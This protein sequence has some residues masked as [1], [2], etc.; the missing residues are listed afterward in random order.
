MSFGFPARGRFN[1]PKY[2]SATDIAG[3]IAD[4]VQTT[5]DL[6][7]VP[8]SAREDKQIRLVEDDGAIFYFDAQAVSGD[9]APVSG[10]GFWIR[11]NDVVTST[12]PE[13]TSAP[14]GDTKGI[15][16]VDSDK[17][18]QIIGGVLE[19]KLDPDNTISF[20][21]TGGLRVTPG[22]VIMHVT[23]HEA[24]GDD[25]LNVAGL[26][27]LL[28]DAQTPL[29]HA[30]THQDGGSDEIATA[31]STANAIPK[32]DS[33]G[34]LES[35]WGGD[36]DTLATLDSS[37]YLPDDETELVYRNI[38]QTGL[39]TGGVVSIN[40]GD[41]TLFDVTAGSGLIVNT[42]TDPDNPTITRVTWNA[43]TGVST[44]GLG[45]SFITYVLINSS[46]ALVQ[47]TTNPTPSQLRS[48][49]LLA[50]LF[51]PNGVNITAA[52]RAI[53]A[54]S[55][56]LAGVDFAKAFGP[57]NIS[58]N[59]FSPNGANLQVDKSSGEI[60]S[61]G[62]NVWTTPSDPHTTVLGSQ[63]PV[64]FL[65][66]VYRD[67]IGGFTFE[68]PTS[69]LDPTRY[70]DGSGTPAVVGA[71]QWTLQRLFL[72]PLGQIFVALGQNLFNTKE[73]AIS[74][75][76][77]P[78]DLPV[79]A[80]EGVMRGWIALRGGATALNSTSDAEFVAAGRLGITDISA[81]TSSGE[82]NEGV[83][84]G[85]DGVGV[86]DSKSG[87]TL[88]F[89]NVAPASP[90]VTVN[91]N[92]A[93]IDID[94]ESAT[95]TQRGAA[96][97]ATQAETDTG[98]DDLRIVTPLK[99][100][101]TLSTRVVGPGSATG[102]AITRYDGTTGKLVKNSGLRITDTPTIEKNANDGTGIVIGQTPAGANTGSTVQVLSVTTTQRDQLVAANGMVIYN[103]TLG[104]L[105]M[106]RNG[107]WTSAGKK[108]IVCSFGSANGTGLAS[109]DAAFTVKAR[110]YFAGTN[111][112]GALS[113]ITII[114][115]AD[116][117][118]GR[119][120]IFDLTN[121]L[122]IGTSVTIPSGSAPTIRTIT[123]ANVPTGQ[124]IWEVQM[125]RDTGTG[126]NAIRCSSLSLVFS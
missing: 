30:S 75:I 87:I 21:T 77:V 48:L 52:S 45:S 92:G 99:L 53:P 102:N 78:I 50:I 111:A 8:P 105:Q 19:T 20:G 73:D 76:G 6:A 123:P 37:G 11:S 3:R 122:I 110:L 88:Q 71:N 93:D 65:T 38:L 124:A 70:D 72:T 84:I 41:P 118:T 44:T 125:I 120:R 74:E 29:S 90:A 39:R 85:V 17:G 33:S 13:A 81:G 80:N 31:T 95:E 51:H 83:N 63:V 54:L 112:W 107:V 15:L 101:T 24:G 115:S 94:V 108:D 12:V 126:G 43:F 69:L 27:G 47:Q 9:V 117:A 119:V 62:S 66:V 121:A 49:I 5:T 97:I 46:G 14:G 89:R 40:G 16:T 55:P 60:F 113:N 82:I 57:L 114:T 91:L 22:V 28:A 7:N 98:T 106:R 56:S 64:T 26:S 42:H 100:A 86:F 35:G 68:S 79:E 18:L 109:V 2:Q 96:E 103:T 58:G 10:S 23:T 34:K 61:I 32:A 4:P 67:G 1:L 36:P 59:V 25:E 104:V 116:T